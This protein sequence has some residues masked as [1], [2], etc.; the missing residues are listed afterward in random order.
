MYRAPK[1]GA[2]KTEHR[3]AITAILGFLA[4]L[5]V[6]LPVGTPV[7]PRDAKNGKRKWMPLPSL[8]RYPGI[9]VNLETGSSGTK[10]K[11][12]ADTWDVSPP[13]WFKY[14][15]RQFTS[16]ARALIERPARHEIDDWIKWLG[17]E[18]GFYYRQDSRRSLHKTLKVATLIERSG[19]QANIDSMVRSRHGVR[20]FEH[21]E[22]ALDACRETSM[23][24]TW[25]YHP[26]DV[27]GLHVGSKGWMERWYAARVLITAPDRYTASRSSAKLDTR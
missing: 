20:A 27:R 4:S 7:F 25:S 10:G 18:L 12:M 13:G 1:H 26:E 8:V 22:Q 11:G 6:R 16:I 2:V 5:D 3:Q 9:R 14:F 24:E 15:P 23:I 17:V 21:F 19:F